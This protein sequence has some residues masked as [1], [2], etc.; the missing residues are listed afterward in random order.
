MSRAGIG[1]TG[2]WWSA[3]AVERRLA[4]E[5]T[6]APSRWGSSAATQVGVINVGR[7]VI[8]SRWSSDTSDAILG[9]K[10]GNEWLVD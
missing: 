9:V 7:S 1:A 2:R 5:L 10:L 3:A 4:G 6:F 8:G